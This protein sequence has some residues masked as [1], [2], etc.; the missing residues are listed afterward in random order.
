MD[1]DV[2]QTIKDKINEKLIHK[3]FCMDV[4]PGQVQFSDRQLLFEQYRLLV[5]ATHKSTEQRASSVTV[6]LTINTLIVTSVLGLT[7]SMTQFKILHTIVSPILVFLILVGIT[8]CC[9]WLSVMSA[10]KNKNLL[11]YYL[12]EAF[13]KKFPSCVFSMEVNLEANQIEEDPV[14][15]ANYILMRETLLPKMFIFT[16]SA[17]IVYGVC[18]FFFK[19]F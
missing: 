11:D 9:N 19:T 15:K 2:T 8:I 12:I 17:F 5:E 3:D 6:Y 16:F 7:V 10:Y 1:P 13:E 18:V 14:K 4:Q